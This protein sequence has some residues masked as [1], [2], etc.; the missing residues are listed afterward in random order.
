MS[1]LEE[2]LLFQIKAAGLPE[3]VREYRFAPPRRWRFDFCWPDQQ[4]AVE[5]E[6][7]TWVRGRHSRGVGY[8]R[9][10]EKMNAAQM[11]GYIVLRFTSDMITSGEA[12]QTIEEVLL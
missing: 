3:P 12:L 7:G 2:T 1:A 11:L 4:I 5:V 9:D 10:C 6:G 8:A